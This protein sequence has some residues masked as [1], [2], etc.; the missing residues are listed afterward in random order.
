[1]LPT[2]ARWATDR[3]ILED[4]ERVVTAWNDRQ[5][6][7]MP[8]LSPRRS[9]QPSPPAIVPAGLLPGLPNLVAHFAYLKPSIL[10][11]ARMS[12]GGRC[13]R[14]GCRGEAF[15]IAVRVLADWDKRTERA[16]NT[17]LRLIIGAFVIGI[18]HTLLKRIA[19]ITIA[20]AKM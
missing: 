6:K 16:R 3:Q 15:L 19:K 17:F 4:A 1:M 20:Q 10:A 13:R 18:I 9:A 7:R 14:S 5:T 12:R 2:A 11:A 8:I